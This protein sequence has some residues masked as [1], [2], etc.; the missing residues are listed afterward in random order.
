MKKSKVFLLKVEYQ[1]KYS[2]YA[3]A[4]GSDLLSVT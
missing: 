2:G 3:W 1:A 4:R